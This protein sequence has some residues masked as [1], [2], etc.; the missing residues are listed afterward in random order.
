MATQLRL[1][2]AQDHFQADCTPRTTSVMHQHT[3]DPLQ[4]RAI[5]AVVSQ[6]DKEHDQFMLVLYPTRTRAMRLLQG[7]EEGPTDSSCSLVGL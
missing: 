7:R 1:Q 6:H 4:M 5:R 3:N 2:A